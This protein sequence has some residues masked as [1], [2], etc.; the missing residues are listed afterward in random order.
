M[1]S[2]E[3]FV[4][5]E[6]EKHTQRIMKKKKILAIKSITAAGIAGLILLLSMSLAWFTF[7]NQTSGGNLNMKGEGYYFELRTEGTITSDTLNNNSEPFDAS[8]YDSVL[9]SFTDSSYAGGITSSMLQTDENNT[10]IKWLLSQEKDAS[11]KV[12]KDETGF[13]V[14][15]INPGD[16]GTLTFYVVPKVSGEMTLNFELEING[17]KEEKEQDGKSTGRYKEVESI[18]K[19]LLEGHL[20]FFESKDKDGYYSGLIAYKFYH[21]FKATADEKHEVTIHWIWPATFGQMVLVSGDN[22]LGNRNP[23]FK[24]KYDYEKPDAPKNRFIVFM[25]NHPHSFFGSSDILIDSKNRTLKSE[26]AEDLIKMAS[27]GE[28]KASYYDDF[29]TA[30]NL[31]DDSIGHNVDYVLVELHATKAEKPEETSTEVTG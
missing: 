14:N 19:S 10:S 21:T 15:G 12:I 9:D 26:Y 24:D 25:K 27:K 3:E 30:Y 23:I 22:N 17:Y 2:Q 8:G 4:K 13:V 5:G 11:G 7:N 31:G 28:Y 1:Q 20:L 6:V 18:D 29:T 16:S